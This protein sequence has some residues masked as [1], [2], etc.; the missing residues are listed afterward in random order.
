MAIAASKV[1]PFFVLIGI[2]GTIKIEDEEFTVNEEFQE[3]AIQ[4]ADAL[5]L[6]EQES[7]R[8]LFVAQDYS[9]ALDRPS[10][11]S[12]I[13]GFH[14]RRQ[15]LLECLR[16]LLK[17][18]TDPDREEHLREVQ[19]ELVC[20]I[21]EVKD[22]PSRNGSLYVRKCLGAMA[23]IEKW[24]QALGDR[25]QGTLVL[26]HVST[27]DYE[28]V[29]RFQQQSL[30]QQHESLSALITHI[31]KGGFTGAE[32]FHRLLD[33]LPTIEKWNYI[34]V[35]YVPIIVAFA[36]QHGSSENGGDA[37][38]ASIL[39]KKIL[40]A[41]DGTRWNLRNLQAATTSWWLAEYSGWSPEFF[42][43]LSTRRPDADSE[44]QNCSEAFLQAV[45]EGAFH[46][47][48]SICCQIQPDEWYHPARTGLIQYL[49]RDTLMLPP[50]TMNVS[51]YFQL[52]VMEQFEVFVE[53]FIT[54]MPDTLRQFQVDEDDQR[55]KILGGFQSGS[56]NSL[57][58][59][60]LHLERFLVIISFA[61]NN[62][63]DAAQSFWVDTDSNLYGFLQWASKRQSTPRV[64]AFCEMLMSIS[65][66]EDC[67]S[68]A[69]NFLLDDGNSTSIKFRRSSSINWAQIINELSLYTSKIR[70]TPTSTRP[71]FR[72]GSNANSDDIDEPESPLMLECYL[73]L[74]SHLCRE[75]SMAR[76]WF[77]EHQNFRVLEVMLHLCS[78]SVAHRL[79]AGAFSTIHAL[80]TDKSLETGF[81]VWNILDQWASGAFASTHGLSRPG[82][83]VNSSLWMEEVTFNPIANHFD[84]ACSFV[85]LLQALVTSSN[86]EIGLHDVLAF[87]EQL[88]AGYRMPGIGP[89]IDLVFD[90]ILSSRVPLI[91]EPSQFAILTYNILDFAATS[92]ATFNE[93]IL[94]LANK[95]TIAV[96]TSIESSSLATYVRLHPF[97]RVME[98]MFN[99]RVLAALF[100][101]AKQDIDEVAMASQT[102]PLMLMLLRAI[103]VMNLVLDS[104]TT[105][106]SLVRPL[107]KSEPSGHQPPVINPTLVSFEDSVASHLDLIVD[108]GLYCGVGNHELALSALKLL[109]KL[110][111][112]RRL[113][114]HFGPGLTHVPNGNRLIAILEQNE[115]LERI[116]KSFSSAML[117]D[118]RELSHGPD[119]PAW[120]IKSAILNFLR[121]GLIESPDRM[122]LAHAMLG[123]SSST[124]SLKME[125]T[126]LAHK[127]S[128]FHS[129]VNLVANYPDGTEDSKQTWAL[130]VRQKGMQILSTLWS[131]P[132]T[133]LF[134]L[135]EL[136]LSDFLFALFLR[137]T[138]IASYVQWDGRSVRQLNF[139][140]TGSAVTLQQFLDQRCSLFEYISVE[141]RLAAVEG[142]PTLK[143]RILSTL[144]GITTMPEGEQISNLTIFDLMDFLDFSIPTQPLLPASQLFADVDFTVA[145]ESGP[146]GE[147]G[148]AN[149]K[150]IEQLLALKLNE[151][152]KTGRLRDSVEEQQALR[153]ANSL[154][155]LF[156]TRNNVETL[157]AVRLRTL[158][159]WSNLLTLVIGYC[160]L[161]QG[162]RT[163]LVLQ[164]LQAI[165]P[166]LES[167]TAD[168]SS[169]AA[170]IG[171]L[172][173]ALMYQMDFRPKMEDQSNGN[174]IVDERLSQAFRIA[175]RAINI[176][177]STA[178][179]R[180]VLYNVCF[181]YLTGI[182]EKGQAS[183]KPFHLIQRLKAS[184]RKVIDII[185]DDAV[186][187]TGTCRI[188]AL[189]LLDSLAAISMREKSNY[190]LESLSRTNFIVVLVEAIVD[191]PTELGE[192]DATGKPPL[193]DSIS[194]PTLLIFALGVHFLLS[195]YDS[196]FS[197][198]LTIS[199]TRAGAHHI[200]EAGLFQ[201]VRASS[202]FSTDPDIGIGK[203]KSS[204]LE[205]SI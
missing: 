25:Q 46:C 161:D 114:A 82:K 85:G 145:K 38:E 80:L 156:E 69:Y 199:Q 180:E 39:N 148:G 61:F 5:G 186:G 77:L 125:Q 154:L 142:I 12:A 3:G 113:N 7:G 24:L 79:Q 43:G 159:A 106:F 66:G 182:L 96:D 126:A 87:P 45:R 120:T 73:R 99:D 16:L 27:P 153:E 97:C 202:L 55:K 67:A 132:L 204:L 52:L 115:D 88:G 14:E 76:S 139:M 8:L 22:G 75:S 72:Y 89:Y 118:S 124:G 53:A 193:C 47:T 40:E 140:S 102:S 190:I 31:I 98:W 94:I 179:L 173:Q 157:R 172:V 100:S 35:H 144:L 122:T 200:V 176:P 11:T 48:L 185:C 177:E 68:A 189:L 136:R 70:E 81:T 151:M 191:I 174:D 110:A 143:A 21:L 128:L 147:V 127:F 163:A 187:A 146:E 150:L 86:D 91:E 130:G 78:P 107:I 149:L 104:Q 92:L 195:Y 30:G 84:E 56:R 9:E 18:A 138:I 93:D 20:E 158:K 188:S 137:Q 65:Q 90:K 23:D 117:F 15:F 175:L 62:R 44:A 95:S 201:A 103:E 36:S 83:A 184:G 105:Y 1:A 17:N 167:F 42:Q 49:L 160:D 134:T 74:I 54:N 166:K 41:K 4:V 37:R 162:G 168:N 57:W 131:S 2:T 58:D 6:D 112:S 141:L 60:D 181:R 203:F 108:L 32:D 33:Y 197:L 135:S 205:I 129:I 19:L 71:A 13:I 192:A 28:E 152:R 164:A 170:V 101:A 196:K 34:A 169:E 119:D 155:L 123:L 26:G 29:M 121:K 183:A 116:R 178:E 64:G 59:Q 50:E 198:L 10:V 63:I 165:L 194:L 133:S 111:S 109:E 171:K 51:S